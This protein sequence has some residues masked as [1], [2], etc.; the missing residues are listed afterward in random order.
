M[1]KGI[2]L[3]SS[4]ALNST[5]EAYHP[6]TFHTFQNNLLNQSLTSPESSIE[7]S[8]NPPRSPVIS[9]DLTKQGNF[10][11]GGRKSGEKKPLTLQGLCMG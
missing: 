11:L 2:A 5:T 10:P 8:S 6:E 9:S 3:P 4:L 7:H 1:A